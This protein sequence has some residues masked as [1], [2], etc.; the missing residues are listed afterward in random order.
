[1]PSSF[2]LFLLILLVFPMPVVLSQQIVD[3]T[4][5]INLKTPAYSYNNGPV[6]LVD[7]Y[8]NNDMSIKN[9]MNPL[10][11]ILRQD[12]YKIQP[13]TGPFRLNI[14]KK[15]NTLVVISPLHGSNVDNWKLPT[16]SAFDPKEIKE[17]IQWIDEGGNLLLVADH[18]PFPGAVKELSDHLGVEWYNGFVIDSVNWGNSVFSKRDGTLKHH[19]LLNGRNQ[20]ERVNWVATYYG[21]GFQ[22]KDSTI[23]GIFGF[24]NPDTV[25]YQTQEAWKMYPDTPTIPANDLFQ[26]AV[27]KRG[28]GRVAIIGEASLFSAQLV[29]KNK[30]PIGINFPNDG[31]NLQFVL[32]IFHWLS[33]SID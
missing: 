23:T 30:N 16:P 31:Q 15:A 6:I 19:R 26:A 24:D 20:N 4:F 17:L 28:K 10:I 3:S 9:R 11:R 27:L 22:I 8:H 21:S 1:M 25:S 18:M 13:N 2:K 7:E 5:T 33:G 32:N 29:G 12:G 14:L